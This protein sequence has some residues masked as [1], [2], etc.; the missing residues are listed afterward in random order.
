MLRSEELVAVLKE[1][2]N[3]ALPLQFEYGM[4]CL[5]TRC[6]QK[7]TFGF[8][9]NQS[10]GNVT[11][12]SMLQSFTFGDNF[13]QFLD[14]MTLPL[15]LRSFTFGLTKFALT[16]LTPSDSKNQQQDTDND[17]DDDHPR[18]TNQTNTDKTKPRETGKSRQDEHRLGHYT[19]THPR[20]PSTYE[21][22]LSY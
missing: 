1:V 6:L 12:S 14:N 22:S 8:W 3:F 20:T 13:N 7:L 21:R 2:V 10:L 16:S 19:P 15:A 18:D 11:L 9:F 4:N 17:D 5:M